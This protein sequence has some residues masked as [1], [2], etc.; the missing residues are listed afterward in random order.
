MVQSADQYAP[1]LLP[2]LVAAGRCAYSSFCWLLCL[3]RRAG[4][5]G[6]AVFPLCCLIRAVSTAVDSPCEH[7]VAA[8]TA[9]GLANENV[10]LR[11][12]TGALTH[13]R[14]RCQGCLGFE[15][16]CNIGE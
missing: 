14:Q 15:N 2:Y 11:L 6:A 16:N 13:Q 10:F 7:R 4:N 5:V 1:E 9:I 8:D 3:I 12:T